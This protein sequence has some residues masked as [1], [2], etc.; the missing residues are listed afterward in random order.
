[1]RVEL[2]KSTEF[3][4]QGALASLEAALTDVLEGTA[5]V[6]VTA[7]I[8][9][10]NIQSETFHF[11]GHT[12]YLAAKCGIDPDMVLMLMISEGLRVG[13]ATGHIPLA[14][15][16][17]AITP[18]LIVQKLGIMQQ[19]L[20]YDFGIRK[21]RIAVLGLNPHAGDEGLLGTDEIERILP[22]IQKANDMGITAMGPY[23]ADGFFA[24][25]NFAKFDAILA[26][27]HDQGLIPFKTLAGETGVNF[28]AGLPIVRTSPAHGTAFAIAGLN[29]ANEESFRHAIYAA[30]D[31]VRNRRVYDEIS[32]NPLEIQER[33]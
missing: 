24:S 13:V 9:K 7:P 17:A 6:L 5:D 11:P 26:M 33:D 2:G 28:T 22:A 29:E 27:Y 16:P 15:V 12:E 4:G 14:N 19:S 21:P 8:N 20:K 31:I 25:G 30:I 18:E 32:A 1:V 23:P 3:G 10:S